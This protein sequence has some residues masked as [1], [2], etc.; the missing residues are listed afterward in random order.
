MAEHEGAALDHD[1]GGCTPMDI[2]PLRTALR[3]PAQPRWLSHGCFLERTCGE[4]AYMSRMFNENAQS[5]HPPTTTG[6]SA[7]SPQLRIDAAKTTRV[8][9]SSRMARTYV[10]TGRGARARATQR[11]DDGLADKLP[12]SPLRPST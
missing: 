4:L 12:P 1:L 9:A 11:K 2:L 5:L 3:A 8:S 7:A 10:N 6:D